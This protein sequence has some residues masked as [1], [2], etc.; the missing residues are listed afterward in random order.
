MI[1]VG[2]WGG[3]TAAVGPKARWR[4][5]KMVLDDSPG[6]AGHPSAHDFQ[7]PVR[8]PE[9]PVM[10]GLPEKW[11]HAHDEWYSQLR[12]PAKQLE[13]LWNHVWWARHLCSQ[14]CFV[15]SCRLRPALRNAVIWTM[16]N[17]PCGRRSGHR[18]R[19]RG[20]GS[21]R[22]RSSISPGTSSFHRGRRP[23]YW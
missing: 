16:S 23:T 3:R 10:R 17:V 14:S 8:T 12:G 20:A 7:I 1:G 2:G 5:G 9:H 15:C 6:T 4:D 11:M 22:P 19:R 21:G 18:R 13:V